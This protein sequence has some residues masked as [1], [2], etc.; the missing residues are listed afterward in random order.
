MRLVSLTLVLWS[1]TLTFTALTMLRMFPA[2][3]RQDIRNVVTGESKSSNCY[4][5]FGRC[6]PHFFVIGV[7][8]GGTTSLYNYLGKHPQVRLKIGNHTDRESGMKEVRTKETNFLTFFKFNQTTPTPTAP[9]LG[10]PKT[11]TQYLDTFFPRI[12]PG[13][14]LI[15]GEASPSYVYAPDV[16]DRMLQLF[17]R[18]RLILMLREPI[19]RAFSRVA[20]AAQLRCDRLPSDS[21]TN[22]PVPEYCQPEGVQRLFDRLVELELEGVETCLK[23]VGLTLNAA[24]EVVNSKDNI[25]QQWN[26]AAQCWKKQTEQHK[27]QLSHPNP[28]MLPA[29]S[30]QFLRACLEMRTISHGLYIWQVLYWL[31]LFP[32]E[33]LLIV[34]SEDFYADTVNVMTRIERHLHLQPNRI[35]WADVVQVKYNVGINRKDK[36]VAFIEEKAINNKKAQVSDKTRSKLQAFFQPYNQ[37][38]GALDLLQPW[39][40]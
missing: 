15:T 11:V 23:Q 36:S 9:H 33:Q 30:A 21:N 16:A 26:N 2:D 38:L 28:T 4:V 37:A 39:S 22:L 13:D 31:R 14:G 19:D 1:I 35:D 18:A 20:H 34:R 6:A 7:F 24:D 5:T 10:M 32:R 29:S 12:Y 27:R 8:K 17:P 3:H 25:Y 40:Y